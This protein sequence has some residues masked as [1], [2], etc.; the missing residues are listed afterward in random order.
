MCL[1]KKIFTTTPEDFSDIALE[2][3][4]FQYV[5]NTVYRQYVQHIGRSPSQIVNIQDIPFLP[6]SFFKTQQVITTQSAILQTFE[7]SGTTGN[8]TSKHHLIATDIYKESLLKG[9]ELVF[10]SPQQ[11]CFVALLPNYLER[12]NS[13]LIYMVNTLM[14][15]SQHPE[16]NYFLSNHKALY[17]TLRKL[18]E[19]QQPTLLFGVSFALL[20]FVE[21]YN[22]SLQ[23]TKIIETGGMKGKRPEITRE[24]LHRELCNAFDSEQIYSEYGM[25]ELLSQAYAQK[26]DTY[27]CPPWMQVLIRETNDPF[28]YLTKNETGGINIIDFANLYSCSFI[29]TQDLGRINSDNSFAVL[30]RFDIA[31]TRGCNLLLAE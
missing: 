8:T 26:T 21:Q 9:F 1:R 3:F 27:C 4:H 23:H 10:G 15:S 2:I 13:S 24:Q 14:N 17:Q 28:S 19:E 18:E 11:Y 12:Q 22:L 29:E 16:N 7:S 20:D 25:T 5:H 30:G 31:E 6:I